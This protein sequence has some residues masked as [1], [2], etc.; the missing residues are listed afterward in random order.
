MI[1]RSQRTL[2]GRTL[3]AS[4]L[5]LLAAAVVHPSHRAWDSAIPAAICSLAGL[6]SVGWT[7][8]TGAA[9]AIQPAAAPR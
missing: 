3:I 4:P 8:S 1:E 2:A 6:G 9:S 7:I 5:L